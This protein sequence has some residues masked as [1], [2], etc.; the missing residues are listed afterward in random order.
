MSLTQFVS[1]MK[2]NKHLKVFRLRGILSYNNRY[3]ERKCF[4]AY[5]FC[6]NSVTAELKPMATMM[7]MS[8]AN[9]QNY[10]N[11]AQ[12]QFFHLH[13]HRLD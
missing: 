13:C 10:K 6:M 8:L 2:F 4:Y 9:K 3:F 1:I 7:Q 12:K 5:I 11:M